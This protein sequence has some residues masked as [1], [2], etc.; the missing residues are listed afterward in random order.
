MVKRL[1][2]AI[3]LQSPAVGVQK[4]PLLLRIQQPF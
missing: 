2:Q 3:N 1:K 4:G